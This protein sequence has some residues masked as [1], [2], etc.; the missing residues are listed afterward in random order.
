MAKSKKITTTSDRRSMMSLMDFEK[1]L[2]MEKVAFIRA[3]TRLLGAITE[4][5]ITF[6]TPEALTKLRSN[7]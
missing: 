5:F 4:V 7:K 6:V 2:I 1:E 3:A